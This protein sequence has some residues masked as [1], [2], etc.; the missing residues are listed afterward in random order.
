MGGVLRFNTKVEDLIT[1][2]GRCVGIRLANGEEVIGSPVIVAIGHSARDS[3]RMLMRAGAKAHW[4]N[5]IGTVEHPQRLSIKVYM[6]MRKRTSARKL[7]VPNPI[8]A[9]WCAHT[10]YVSGR[11]G[12]WSNLCAGR[13]VVNGMFIL[14][15]VFGQLRIIVDVVLMTTTKRCVVVCFVSRSDRKRC[16]AGGGDSF[17]HSVFQIS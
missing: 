2:K 1:D 15:D 17:L 14:A 9:S 8:L 3:W 4:S 7:F 13:V 6:V 16:L 5:R 10:L 12:C 11:D